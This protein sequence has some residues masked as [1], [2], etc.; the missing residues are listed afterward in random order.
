MFICFTFSKCLP[1]EVLFKHLTERFCPRSL[2]PNNCWP[3]WIWYKWFKKTSFKIVTILQLESFPKQNDL[4]IFDFTVQKTFGWLLNLQG[5][6]DLPTIHIFQVLSGGEE[7]FCQCI[8]KDLW[9]P[10]CS[11]LLRGHPYRIFVEYLCPIAQLWL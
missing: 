8:Q 4:V 10:F 2:W 6:C 9:L 3:I 7:L 11:L 1:I 5:A